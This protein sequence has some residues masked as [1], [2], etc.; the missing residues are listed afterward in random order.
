MS[1]FSRYLIVFIAAGSALLTADNKDEKF[2]PGPASSYP[3]KQTIDHVTIAAVPYTTE[4]QA[5]AA[6]GKSSPYKYGVLPVLVVM[7]NDTG[8][9]LKLDRIK[10]AYNG[11]RG[12]RV[13]ATPA[14]D[15]KFAI[16]PQRPR[17]MGSGR[18]P[19]PLPAKKNPLSA[20]EIEGRALSAQA[21]PPGQ[22]A[23]GF[24]YFLTGLQKGATLYIGGIT[25]AN[26]GNELF[27]F[28]IPL[29]Q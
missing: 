23:S 12:D 16:A 18:G 17:A 5:R 8:K 20:W 22:S 6:F 4:E 28:E 24:L 21:L 25:E 29:E 7:Q 1:L 9:T 15:V 10:A 2:S 13:E 19:L 26:S 14:R 27:Y 11:P 3:T